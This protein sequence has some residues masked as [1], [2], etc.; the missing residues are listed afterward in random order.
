MLEILYAKSS[1]LPKPGGVKH[2]DA[3]FVLPYTDPELTVR[4]AG[5]LARRALAAGLLVLVEDDARI[6]FMQI[7]NIL[8]AHSAS[9]YFGYLAQDAYPGDGWLRSALRTLDTSSAGLLAFN[10]GRFHGTLA[11]FGLARR[12]WLSGLYHKF[13]F[14]PEYRRH[15]GDT[16]LSAI[17]LYQKQLVYNPGCVMVEVDY[18]KHEKE[19]DPDDAALYK[20]REEEGFGG[21]IEPM[22]GRD[23]QEVARR[24]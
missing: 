19:N 10:D 20:R 16:E 9:R 22:R 8:C 15:F 3:V 21:I 23:P 18:E 1:S 24:G 6:G 7:A 12:G 5:V 14:Y 13:L 2:D 11:V 17:A 4:L